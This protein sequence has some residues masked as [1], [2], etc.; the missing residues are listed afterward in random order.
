MTYL[1][2]V[3]K[4]LKRLRENTVNSVDETLYSRLVGEFVNDANRMV[5]DSWDWS[6]LRTTVTQTVTAADG[7][8]SARSQFMLPN[9][10]SQFKTLNVINETQKC[11]MNLGTQTE[12]Q[13]VKYIDPVTPSV[14]THYVYGGAFS[15]GVLV[16]V[17]PVPDKTYT[18]QFNIVDRTEELTSDTQ[19]ILAPS[20]PV[21]QFAH[22]MAVE[23]RGETGG[24]TAAML[25]G[26]AKSSLSDAISFDAARFPTETIWVDV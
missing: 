23:E 22:A 16:D 26:V 25:T 17:Y 24:T 5:E 20:L 8:I 14:P 7:I 13:K 15:Q 18:L 3:N 1:Q 12:L 10:T 4:V 11:F 6:A 9:V 19:N 2:A 21:V